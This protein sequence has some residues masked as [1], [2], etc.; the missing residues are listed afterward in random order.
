M[1]HVAW[2]KIPRRIQSTLVNHVQKIS[3]P[4]NTTSLPPGKGW[5]SSYGGNNRVKSLQKNL[6]IAGLQPYKG[7]VRAF[8]DIVDYDL[9]RGEEE[10]PALGPGHDGVFQPD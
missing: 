6:K 7:A 8:P 2:Q 9:E 10:Q 3:D 1:L 4:Q 5:P